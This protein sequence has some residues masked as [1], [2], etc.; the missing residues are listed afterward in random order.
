VGVPILQLGGGALICND[1]NMGSCSGT[2]F[3]S[4]HAVGVAALFIQDRL[5]KGL[6]A[7]LPGVV[8]QAL[9]ETG[10]C[11]EAGAGAGGL[12]HGTAG[13][14]SVWPSDPDGLAEP[15]VRAANVVNFAAAGVNDV[16]VTSVSTPSPAVAGEAQDVSVGVQNQGTSSETFD[17]S[18]A[19]ETEPL[20]AI[21]PTPQSVSLDPGGS[22][23]V[24]FSWRPGIDGNHVLTGT[25]GPVTGETDTADNNRSTTVS[26][27]VPNHDVAVSSI[28]APAFVPQGE[29][30]AISVVVDNEGTED[31][32][33]TVAVVATLTADGSLAGSVQAINTQP[34]VITVGQSAT[35]TFDWD[36]T[37]ASAGDHTLTA[38]ASLQ[39]AT[40]S[41]PAD[42]SQSASVPVVVPVHDVAITSII[43]QD[44][45]NHPTPLGIQV[46]VTNEGTFEETFQVEMTDTPP[47]GGTAGTWSGAYPNP[48]TVTLAAGAS[49]TPPLIFTWVTDSASAGDHLLTATASGVASETDTADNSQSKT[50]EVSLEL[51]DF[52]ITSVTA[53]A[54]VTEGTVADV[55]VEVENLGVVEFTVTVSMEDPDVTGSAAWSPG[56]LSAPQEVTLAGGTLTTLTFTWDTTPASAGD[57]LLRSV[58][59]GDGDP[60]N[61][62]GITDSTVLLAAPSNLTA[63]A[64]SQTTGRGKTK[65]RTVWVNLAWD[66]NSASEEGYVVE[67]AE[68]TVTGKGKK[69]TTTVGPYSEIATTAA[70]VTSYRDDSAESGMPHRYRVKASHSV[71]GDSDYSNEA[72][73]ETK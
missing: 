32:S 25:A 66:D 15:L 19:D 68:V 18:L 40:D 10:E 20:A 27:Q 49:T 73:A 58:L 16:A 6:P 35:F 9:I 2:S 33:V 28:T 45:V 46:N 24:T 26:V 42:N 21:S 22:T 72:E 60:F 38:T 5:D 57:H 34:I 37:T 51:V 11:Y 62:I 4:P 65:T 63:T 14:P 50:V 61:N 39:G 3:A 64:G 8:R 31:E 67:R 43:S 7:P 29:T 30:A 56:I 1:I 44:V 53:P 69:K 59:T 23:T 48:R 70:D 17:V 55:S 13:C 36:T 12:F 71:V 41:D 52:T 54:S 47:A